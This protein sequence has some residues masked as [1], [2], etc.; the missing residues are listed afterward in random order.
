MN[1]SRH[2][3]RRAA[4]L[5]V[6]ASW[7]STVRDVSPV[8][9][10]IV[11]MLGCLTACGGGDDG[12]AGNGNPPPAQLSSYVG[13]TGV[14]VAYADPSTGNFSAAQIGSYAGKRQVL[15]G[16]I[17]F[18]T[19]SSVGQPA[20]VEIYKAG[21]GHIY[22]LDLTTFGTPSAQQL[23]SESAA[24]VDDTCS[25][26]GTEVAGANTD[27]VGV[28]FT[29]DLQNT[30][31]SSYFYRLP[32]PDGVCD[33]ADDVVQMVKTG[34]APTD[35]PITVMAM[36][37]V[38]VRT[39]S[40]GISGFVVKSGASLELV[41]SNFANPVVLGTFATP[42]GVATALAVGTTQ[43]YPT[44][45]LFIVDGNIVYVDYVAHTTSAT[46]FTIPNWTVT[47]TGA[48]FAASPTTLY[49]SVNTAASGATPAS[50]A[51][52][53]MPADGSAAPAVVD[54]ETGRIVGLQ[55]P[56]QST[57]LIFSVEAPA[58][59]LRALP[60]SGG[61]AVTLVTSTQNG[62]NFTATATNV[63]YTTWTASYDSTTNVDTH[64]GTTSG[65]VGVNGSVVQA[66]LANS[67]FMTGGEQSP[68]PDDT[69]TTQT[70][71]VTV[72]QITGL[73]PV[74][75]T[76]ATTGEQYVEDGVSGG[77]L[78]SIDTTSNQP[79]ATI[80]TLP[81]GTATFLSGTF[82]GYGD[83]GFIEATTAVSTQDPAT[84][85][86]YLVNSQGANS[87]LRVTDNL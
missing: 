59:S 17:D 11:A 83:T 4:D 87:L 72:F 80:G 14:F 21:D 70:P 45:Q 57:N 52:Y 36:P 84:R 28:F 67:A 68:W 31:N 5:C 16:S 43:G 60:A 48:T 40:G 1:L 63:Y 86:L 85:D 30:T 61:P 8:P 69:T 10:L 81:A 3:H 9:A 56:V 82:R 12:Y 24:T 15:H 29:A 20:G 44:G 54:T 47:N 74:T 49:F 41:D 64:S 65:I 7:T 51:L 73:S 76:N 66:P 25:L 77:T 39:S 58:F 26:T 53:A 35:T 46:L 23:S 34:M 50:A 79:I 22:A 27:Y 18:L 42:I 2:L 6:L 62:G 75:V 13:T 33:T 78:T 37:V 55:F 38:T 32:G 71:Y 19:G